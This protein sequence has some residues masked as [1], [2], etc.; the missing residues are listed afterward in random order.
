MANVAIVESGA[1]VYRGAL[2]RSWKNTAGLHNSKDD[3]DALAELGIYPLEEVTPSVD[4]DTEILDGW[5]EDIQADKVVLTHTKRSK[6]SEELSADAEAAA[7][8]YKWKRER[9]YPEIVDQL[10][11]IYHNG[12]DGWKA[13]IKVTKDKYPKPE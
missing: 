10:D 9:E 5:T 11:D 13:T 1:V 3:W 12:I 6:T 2:P 7:T 8:E 4:S